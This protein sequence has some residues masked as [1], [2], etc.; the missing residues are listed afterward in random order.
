MANTLTALQERWSTLYRTTLPMLA[1]AK[2]PAQSKWPVALD[3]CFARIILD[4]AVG[5][6]KPWA[7]VVQAPAVKNMT[8]TQ[9][10]N[11]ISL[12]E[13]IVSG[14]VDLVA[15]DVKSLQ[16][17]GKTKAQSTGIKREMAEEGA[18]P[19][20]GT[21]DAPRRKIQKTS[22]V[23]SFFPPS[24]KPE[25]SEVV[26]PE[27][28]N[29]TQTKPSAIS[30]DALHL[31]ATSDLT[32]FRKQVLALLCQVPA[33]QYTTYAAMSN[34]I[35]KTT[36]KTCARAIGNA[37]RNNPFAPTVPCHRVLA[38]DGR[39]GGFGG[40]WGEEGKLAA[41]KKKLLRDEGVRFDGGGKVVGRPF[42]GFK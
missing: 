8:V 5:I 23:S 20:A 1:K 41:Q 39:I 13:S 19:S 14:D 25:T 21:D 18:E 37:M 35:S 9:L 28:M 34:H 42:Q 17:R 27:E 31:I 40:H 12:G 30:A 24:P 16:L 11:A 15:L 3:H 22:P 26:A 4:N 2:D 29:S 32:P 36:H 7:D 10:E 6:D 38:A 33:G